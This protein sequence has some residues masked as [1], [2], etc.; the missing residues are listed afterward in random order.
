MSGAPSTRFSLVVVTVDRDPAD[1]A[2]TLGSIEDQTWPDWEILREPFPTA[3]AAARGAFIGLIG[4]GDT[5]APGALAALAAALDAHPDADLAYTDEDSPAGA[6]R[7]P[8]WSPERLRHQDYLGGL[9]VLRTAL[10]APLAGADNINRA[11]G[12]TART[13]VHLRQV[14][15][16]RRAEP[17]PNVLDAADAPA[18]LAAGRRLSVIIPT[19]GQTGIS[20]GRPNPL[21]VEA[22]RSALART[23]HDNLEIVVVY[24][25]PTPPT[26]LDELRSLAGDR[27]VLVAFDEPFNFSRKCNL[28]VAASTGEVVVLLNDDVQ[29]ISDGWLE[30]LVAPLDDPS[31][32]LTGAKLLYEDGTIQHAG[33]VYD[34]DGYYHPYAQE[35]ADSLIDHGVLQVSR[36]VSGVTGACAALRRST[37]DEVG[38][39]DEALPGNYNDV[40]LTLKIRRAGYR[41]LWRA[42]VVLFHFESQSRRAA[43]D[44][45]EMDL[46]RARWGVPPDVDPYLP[47]EH[48]PRS[49]YRRVRR[50]ARLTLW[51]IQRRTGTGTSRPPTR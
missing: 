30:H 42:D 49:P 13:V 21:V 14:L 34:R 33:L 32:G 19:R 6:F 45:W 47:I 28:G 16:H 38:G 11:V 22:V 48:P 27:L 51:A 15:Y 37:Y 2:A 1:V 44:L 17:T 39:L 25:P 43:V 46:M 5:L 31:V 26:V 36:E 24:D 3:L 35:P 10:A 20:F 9:T 4:A 29:V 12:R 50:M 23:R 41:I 8:D 40:D 7:K 18:V